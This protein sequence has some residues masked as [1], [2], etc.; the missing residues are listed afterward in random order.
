MAA[1]TTTAE[2][3]SHVAKL[4]G[5]DSLYMLMWAVQIICAA[6]LT[7]ITTRVLGLGE[8]GTVTSANAIMQVL[9]VFAGLGL[10]T[11]VQREYSTFEN[12]RG[13]RQLVLAALGLTVAVSALAW[14]TVPLWAGAL[15]MGDDRTA[16][17]WAVLWAGSSA[18]TTVSLG[19]LRS[20]DKL[21]MF[22]V[23]SF[24]QSV[25]AEAL[26]LG[27][28]KFYRPTAEAFLSGQVVAQ[29]AAAFLGLAVAPPALLLWRDKHVLDR[30]LRFALPLVP[31]AL[32]TFVLSVSD[33]LIVEA[34][35]G[36]EAVARYQVAYNVAS[37]PM[38]LLSVLNS[39]WMPRFFGISD[40]TERRRALA[41]SRDALYRLMLPVVTG[42]A[43]GAPLV[44]RI[45]APSSYHPAKLHFVVSLVLIT[46][47]PY[48]GQ[49][50]VTRT[51]M[52][53]GRTGAS[54]MATLAA[55]VANVGLNLALVPRFGIE[56]CAFATLAA[57]AFLYVLLEV[58]GRRA[59]VPRSPRGLQARL[60][61]VAALALG[62]A[63]VPE[64]TMTLTLRAIAGA[65]AGVWFL[66]V[67]RTIGQ[68]NPAAEARTEPAF[69]PEATQLLWDPEATQLLW[70]GATV[71]MA[72]IVPNRRRT[73]RRQ[74]DPE[75]YSGPAER[76]FDDRRLAGRH[77]RVE[78][79]T[80]VLPVEP[81]TEVLRVEPPTEV[82]RVEPPTEVL[83]APL[84]APQPVP[85]SVPLSVPPPPWPP[86]KPGPGE[87][88]PPVPDWSRAGR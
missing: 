11:A 8:F 7:P 51:L 12:P 82:L 84:S 62:S 76:R 88:W 10:Q 54:A 16:L 1:G 71:E 2:E 40:R 55:A 86:L 50:A 64:S 13:A 69:D 61:G 9:F 32:S 65:G 70:V 27:L 83:P 72:A 36:A 23:V 18:I 53:D 56:G 87:P 19:L 45:W 60:A 26:A 33:R 73:D 24:V 39:A 31:A 52:A 14:W 28:V 67:L 63:W 34:Q 20:L 66:L 74:A 15:E 47:I 44:L 48:A 59:R 21:L 35:L 22:S 4:F 79:P 30:A 80:E 81:P 38:L 37:M 42:F 85:P 77:W 3:Q 25:V 46:A 41:S 17:R 57:Y 43:C 78:S 5:R 6:L 68:E 58:I 75:Q 49:L 29:F